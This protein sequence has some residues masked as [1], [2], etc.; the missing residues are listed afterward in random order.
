MVE[1]I[2]L[3][4]KESNILMY[5]N[6]KELLGRIRF[7]KWVPMSDYTRHIEFFSDVTVRFI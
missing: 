2:I 7:D 6:V 5:R 4:Y 3:I 1:I